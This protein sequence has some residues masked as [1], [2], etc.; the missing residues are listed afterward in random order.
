MDLFLSLIISTTKIASA[1]SKFHSPIKKL[2]KT[3][4]SSKIYKKCRL[5][6]KMWYNLINL[7][8]KR[9]LKNKKIKRKVHNQLKVKTWVKIHLK[10][11][12]KSNHQREL[13]LIAL[14]LLNPSKARTKYFKTLALAKRKKLKLKQ[15]KVRKTTW[16]NSHIKISIKI[17]WLLNRVKLH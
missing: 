13:L 6:I 2:L 17:L 8:L 5:T 12:L 4:I 14:L 11:S 9:K 16:W 7:R 10:L 1:A 15:M 3:L